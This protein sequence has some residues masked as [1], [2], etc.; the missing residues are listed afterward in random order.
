MESNLDSLLSPMD[1][2]PSQT[3]REGEEM[4]PFY[5]NST[6]ACFG[7]LQIPIIAISLIN[8]HCTFLSCITL[9]QFFLADDHVSA[10]FVL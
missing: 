10:S 3:K 4:A 5:W 9:Q 2:Y 1:Y 8:A 7:T 6:C